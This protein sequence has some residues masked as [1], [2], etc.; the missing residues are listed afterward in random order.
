MQISVNLL[1]GDG[2]EILVWKAN[3]VQETASAEAQPKKVSSASAT[4]PK[5][6][7]SIANG[8]R[9]IDV[10]R[11]VGA[12]VTDDKEDIEEATVKSTRSVSIEELDRCKKTTELSQAS[13][14]PKT[15]II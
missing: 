9:G 11:V 3:F 4:K 15:V 6:R 8:M 10:K 1:G 13:D 5:I 14:P 2:N 12:S 7:A